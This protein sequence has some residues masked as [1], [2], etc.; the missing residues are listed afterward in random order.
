M[1]EV[2][3]EDSLDRQLREAAPY[4]DDDGFTGRVLKQLPPARLAGRRS[5][6]AL[7]LLGITILASGLSYVLSGG[8]RFIEHGLAWLTTL[9][10]LW[11]FALA[12]V[13]GI[14]ATALGIAAALTNNRRL[15]AL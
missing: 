8:G 9:P 7:I 2:I 14:L 13:C 11:V 6:R 3:Q 10:L 12:L 15:Q 5:V 4:I 1:D